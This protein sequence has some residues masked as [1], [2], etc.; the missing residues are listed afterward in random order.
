MKG[1]NVADLHRYWAYGTS[2]KRSMLS[3]RYFNKV[4]LACLLT[5]IVGVDG[6]LL[7][8]TSST[9][10]KSTNNPSTLLTYLSQSPS[11]FGFSGIYAPRSN[12]VDFLMPEFAQVLRG[13]NNKEAIRLNYAGCEGVCDAVVVAPGFD[14]NC[15]TTRVPYN[16]SY[17]QGDSTEL[18]SISIQFDGVTHND[19]SRTG[20]S[21]N[22]EILTKFKPDPVCQGSL[23]ATRCELQ[24][25]KVQYPVRI[26]NGTITLTTRPDAINDT[27]EIQYPPNEFSA[28]GIW[29]S[30][31]GGIAFAAQTLYTSNIS[32]VFS[33]TLAV[34]GTGLM[35]STYFNSDFSTYGQCNITWSDPTADVL[36]GIREMMFRSAIHVSNNSTPQMV[37]AVDVVDRLF[38]VSDFRFLAAAVAV[39]ILNVCVILPLFLGWWHL[40]RDVSLSPIE[41]TKAFRA[42]L[43]RAS[44]CNGDNDT[45]LKEVG[46]RR[47]KYGVIVETEDQLLPESGPGGKASGRSSRWRFDTLGGVGAEAQYTRQRLEIAD[48]QLVTRPVEG[49][50]YRD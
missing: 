45:L 12:E 35:G 19:P 20:G 17:K 42:P 3:G 4:A 41:T 10:S 11:P 43:L 21:G 36:A 5:T 22:I 50:A 8:R 24:V 23:V 13:F 2:L 27:V 32:Y 16:V 46:H 26:S 49:V 9:I 30:T 40:G 1:G 25:S 44:E 37:Q 18:G 33:G 28:T 47:A 29:P 38:Y 31:I 6:P 14:R 39:M 7:Q 34:E 15:T 48:P